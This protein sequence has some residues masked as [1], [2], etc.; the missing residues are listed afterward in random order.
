MIVTLGSPIYERP[1][2]AFVTCLIA[3]LD[4]LRERGHQADWRYVSNITHV[5]R[6]YLVADMLK[7][8]P[9]V[10]VQ[11]DGDHQWEAEDVVDAIETV[12]EGQADIIGFSHLDRRPMNIREIV[13]CS[14]IVRGKAGWGFE[15]NGK[16]YIEVDA[17]GG[18][19]LV[20]SRAC[21]EKMSANVPE[22]ELGEV[23]AIFQFPPDGGGE[24]SLFCDKWRAT[25]GKVHCDVT[26]LVGHIGKII[27]AANPA[28][29]IDRYEFEAGE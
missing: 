7:K 21:I 14:P 29:L 4:L 5:A 16:H 20:T 22:Q 1:E 8:D 25:G 12:A 11:I 3:T 6:N 13:W 19:I 24:D 18:G 27:Y 9:S 15:R 10:L 26:S 23:P 28:R 2:P 17:V